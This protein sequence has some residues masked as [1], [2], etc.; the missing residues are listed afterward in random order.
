MDTCLE[1]SL[2][3]SPIWIL[4]RSSLFYM[5][6]TS[7][8]RK[9]KKM[10][11]WKL[12]TRTT[13]LSRRFTTNTHFLYYFPSTHVKEKFN[14]EMDKKADQKI[15]LPL[16]TSH[17]QKGSIPGVIKTSTKKKNKIKYTI[18]RTYKALL[19][20]KL[21]LSVSLSV[22]WLKVPLPTLK[23]TT[24]SDSPCVPKISMEDASL[25]SMHLQTLIRG[26]RTIAY[27][28]FI[29][30]FPLTIVHKLTEGRE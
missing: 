17:T 3:K 30:N 9:T 7:Y 16:K 27:E 23:N 1:A 20:L 25:G 12:D 14:L 26:W 24:F 22:L 8:P 11:E 5:N 15:L 29:H 2:I 10:N 13:P 21:C 4:N 18:T 28:I 6:M 19:T